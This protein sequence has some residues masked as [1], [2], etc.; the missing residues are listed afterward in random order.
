MKQLHFNKLEYF[1]WIGLFSETRKKGDEGRV[2]SVKR[3]SS[4]A[5]ISQTEKPV[6][7]HRKW[8]KKADKTENEKKRNETS[9][10]WIFARAETRQKARHEGHRSDWVFERAQ[11]CVFL[12]Q[13][14][15]TRILLIIYWVPWKSYYSTTYLE[16]LH[17][18]KN[19]LTLER[20]RYY[21]RV[22][23]RD[24]SH[25]NVV[26]LRTV[27]FRGFLQA[28]LSILVWF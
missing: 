8:S 21:K 1:N 26:D 12:R 19:S 27:P 25:H 11:V 16:C 2:E 7:T 13:G 23:M 17:S 28:S 15:S 10:K 14:F 3:S 5:I 4:D 22:E 6:K 24:T 18:A 20:F 9:S